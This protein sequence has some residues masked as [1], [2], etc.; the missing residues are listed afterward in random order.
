M[1]N[2]CEKELWRVNVCVV[3]VIREPKKVHVCVF[4][5]RIGFKNTQ[6]HLNLEKVSIKRI[7]F[8]KAAKKNWKK[9]TLQI[10]WS[11]LSTFCF[12]FCGGV[13]HSTKF[14]SNSAWTASISNPLYSL[15]F[16]FYFFT[17]VLVTRCYRKV[18]FNC[19]VVETHYIYRIIKH[20]LA[21]W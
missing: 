21:H 7:K 12:C 13:V 3:H 16:R 15:R 1:Q 14:F 4:L 20:Y 10:D 17:L 9:F 8:N 11:M 2:D 19:S 18:C 5:V 6:T